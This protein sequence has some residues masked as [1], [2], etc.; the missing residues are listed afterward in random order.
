MSSQHSLGAGLIDSIQTGLVVAAE[1]GGNHLLAFDE[2]LLEACRELQGKCVA[3]EVTDLDFR[4]YCHPGNWGIRLSRNPPRDEVDASISG[5]VMALVN[6]AIQPDKISTSMRERV[7]F[8]GDVGVAQKLQKIIGELD[9]DWEEIL[10]QYTGDLLAYQIHQGADKLLNYLQQSADSLLQTSSEYLREE[11]RLTP[12]QVEFE[13]FSSR[14]TELKHDVERSE[15]RLQQ[16]L[17][18]ANEPSQ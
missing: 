7:S 18:R 3:I 15:A 8:Q 10:A 2:Q 9:I 5:R 16:L 13:A 1:I 4:V 11:A 17:D 6:L 12:T 14:L